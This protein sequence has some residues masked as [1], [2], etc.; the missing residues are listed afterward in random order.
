MVTY[1]G[2]VAA[3][4]KST[5]TLTPSV[6]ETLRRFGGWKYIIKSDLR[7]A[8]FQIPLHHDSMKYCAVVTPFKGVRVYTRAAMG[9]PGSECALDEILSRLAGDLLQEGSVLRTAD[10]IYVGSDN[11][12]ELF[13]TWEKLLIRLQQA[14][15]RLSG[16]KTEVLPSTCMIL[17][18][19]WSNGSL[20]ASP[21]HV[22]ALSVCDLPKTVK[23][24]R[25]YIGAYKVVAR[26]L[27]H[28]SQFLSPL[29]DLTAGKQSADLV[30]W[31]TETIRSFKKSQ[32]HL[33]NCS[34]IV[35]PS[36]NDKLWIVTDASSSKFGIGATLVSTSPENANPSLC[37]FF[38]AKLRSSHDKWLPCE[39]ECLAIATSINHFR[40]LIL[41]SKYTT[42]VL[43]DSRPVIQAFE[44]FKQGHFSTSS[45]MQSFL[46]AATQ[47]NI[48]IKHIKGSENS[49]SDFASRN[50]VNCKATNCSV[51]K[52]ITNSTEISVCSVSVS[53]IVNGQV[54]IP[55]SNPTAWL[56]IQLNCP[57]VQLARKHIQEGTRPQKK[58]K[59][60]RDVKQLI[61]VCSVTSNGLLIVKGKDAPFLLP[62]DL[63]VIPTSYTPGLLTA[64]HLQLNH[65]S[66]HQLK[67]VFNRQFYAISSDKLIQESSQNC[68]QCISL[69]KFRI[70][71]TPDSTSAP[72]NTVGSNF[73][74][75]IIQRVSQKI[76]VLSEEVT[77]FTQATL[78]D[79][80]NH[81]DVLHGL[82]ELIL[83]LHPPCSPTAVL[84][85]D[86]APAMQTLHR[87]QA[88]QDINIQIELGNAKNKNKLATIDK[89]IQELEDEITRI[90]NPNARL[91]KSDLSV[92]VSSLNSRI[93][94]SGLSAYELWHR[95]CQ[96]SKNEINA[97][98][99]VFIER[100]LENRK[101]A[102]NR[103]HPTI[104][105]TPF[106]IGS[107]VYIIDEKTKNCRRPR[108][109]VNNI[110]G[111]WLF[112]CKLTDN[113]LRS[114][115]YK[116]HKNRCAKVPDIYSSTSTQ[117]SVKLPEE[118]DDSSSIE[119]DL[120]IPIP[121][122]E[123][124]V[125][126]NLMHTPV[127]ALRR[128]TRS[129]NP[130]DR[131][132]MCSYD[133]QLFD[134]DHHPSFQVDQPI[135]PQDTQTQQAAPSAVG[136]HELCIEDPV[137]DTSVLHHS[138]SHSFQP[139]TRKSTR[140]RKP[141]DRFGA[142]SDQE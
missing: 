38:S 21:H 85:L 22:A 115:V 118:D 91:C 78:I 117:Q 11:L 48:D 17:G 24:L 114:R 135:T 94:S 67:Q 25:S 58:L 90:A 137:E 84:K 60:L 63:I 106:Q 116:I 120:T 75:D 80:E 125:Q 7:K 73:A 77:K 141:P 3:H 119:S 59:N 20:S 107:I 69:R 101:K 40:S 68:H 1:F 56:Q 5:P 2:E 32:D 13:A 71:S 16:S 33:S 42:T 57:I 50:S 72:Y 123:A 128:S 104:S 132:G 139:P 18:W 109:I 26:V 52:F 124:P 65:P 10:D 6:D 111:V 30:S 127:P 55:F 43:T 136:P 140:P 70:P 105:S 9:M 103:N 37:S 87:S 129:R 8:Y 44:R 39:I 92:A 76:L 64:M 138:V 45:R 62:N 15:L 29:D 51:C 122:N 130:P 41:E 113:Q 79:S 82:K 96:F 14:D 36:P 19:V 95:R 126:K 47:N 98:D 81:H 66:A 28:C 131:F 99:K 12:H 61:R 110:D 93:R 97:A 142:G 89:Q 53:D 112:V 133:D 83:P 108:Y 4:N 35:L 100:Q 102:N 54:R 46:L 23:S 74:A 86:P 49:L 31:S 134:Y 121:S 34:P 27:K 88:L